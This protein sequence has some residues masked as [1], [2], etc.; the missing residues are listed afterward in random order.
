MA[1]K[2]SILCQIYDIYTLISFAFFFIIFFEMFILVSYM[3][4]CYTLSFL[5]DR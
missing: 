3:L 4:I 2:Y 5:L 1:L